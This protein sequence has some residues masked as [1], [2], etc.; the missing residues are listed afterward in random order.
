MKNFVLLGSLWK[1]AVEFVSEA[2]ADQY[3]VQR[4]QGID[5][6]KCSAD[7]VDSRFAGLQKKYLSYDHSQ[8]PIR[9]VIVIQSA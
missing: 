4:C 9:G 8:Y 5:Y 2:Q 7:E 3:I 1:R 6:E